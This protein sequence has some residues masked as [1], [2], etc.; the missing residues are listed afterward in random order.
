[1]TASIT[2]AEIVESMGWVPDDPFRPLA[3][4]E[5]REA[6]VALIEA[7]FAVVPAWGVVAPGE[8]A[9]PKRECAAKHTVHKGWGVEDQVFMQVDHA[10]QWWTPEL[11]KRRAVDN[12]AVVCYGSGVIVADADDMAKFG[13]WTSDNNGLPLTLRASTGRGMHYYFRP[14]HDVVEETPKAR[15][16]L[17][18][19]SGGGAGKR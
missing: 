10:A 17:G 9:C 6:A 5:A 19:S 4:D 8:C 2:W 13:S 1:M 7:G 14:P 12:I 16:K 18:M 11:Q 15:N 3:V